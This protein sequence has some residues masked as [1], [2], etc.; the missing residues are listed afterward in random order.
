[1]HA[2]G[3]TLLV[4][5]N[6]LQNQIVLITGAGSGIGAGV[7]RAMASEGATVVINHPVLQTAEAAN[8]VLK[9][10][11]NS[12]GKGITYQCDVSN[13]QQVVQMFADVV[14]QFGTLDVLVNN[15]GLQRDAA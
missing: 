15:A 2:F 10:I 5:G 14:K 3:N 9:E 6:K 11:E 7:A 13:E 4:M 12:G 1:M 8:G